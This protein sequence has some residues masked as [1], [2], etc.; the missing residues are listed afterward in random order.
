M[1][2]YISSPLIQTLGLKGSVRGIVLNAP[3]GYQDLLAGFDDLW[4]EKT[5][6]LEWV[7]AF[8]VNR[9]DLET[10]FPLIKE[11]LNSLGQIWICWP[12]KSNPVESDLSEAVVREIGLE[13]R[14]LEVKATSMTDEWSGMK[15]V[16]RKKDR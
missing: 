8:F 14:L 16:Y 1:A 6:D 12:K 13:C 11:R 15:F 2:G 7:Q 9:A 4:I 3:E 5:D 10:Q